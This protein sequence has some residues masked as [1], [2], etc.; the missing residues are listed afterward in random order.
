MAII[1]VDADGTIFTHCYPKVGRDIGAA[2]VLKELVDNGHKLILWTMR[3]DE[4]LADAVNWYK[5]NGIPLFGIN[6]N[7]EQ[8]SWTNSPKAYANI[9]LDDA[10]LGIP[11][12]Y[13]VLEDRPY[14]DWDKTRELL[15]YMGLI[16]NV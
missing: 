3:S 13:S 11:L 12:T 5:I 14:V 10:A 7:P 6:E 1:A 9:Y 8:H 4:Y 15:V 16:V 2:P